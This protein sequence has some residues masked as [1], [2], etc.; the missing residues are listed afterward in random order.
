MNSLC[1]LFEAFHRADVGNGAVADAGDTK[2]GQASIGRHAV[3]TITLTGNDTPLQIRSISASS[4]NPRMKKP[5]AP[6]VAYTFAL[7]RASPIDWAGSPL[8][9]KNKSV[10]ALRKRSTLFFPAAARMAAILRACRSIA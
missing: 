2:F 4:C 8:W 10:R 3:H 9:P 1:I 6:A 7:S 5:D